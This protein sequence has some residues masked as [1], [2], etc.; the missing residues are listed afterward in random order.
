MTRHC[1]NPFS[2]IKSSVFFLLT[3][4]LNS[5]SIKFGNYV[6]LTI[7]SAAI[8]HQNL[9]KGVGKSIFLLST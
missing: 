6:F 7:F 8:Y 2:H 4:K 5:I 9:V 1:C 3:L